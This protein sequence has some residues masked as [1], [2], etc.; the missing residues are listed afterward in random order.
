VDD[1]RDWPPFWHQGVLSCSPRAEGGSIERRPGMTLPTRNFQPSC[2]CLQ[3][4]SLVEGLDSKIDFGDLEASHFEIEI[5][6]DQGQ[7]GQLFGQHLVV[8]LSDFDK[9][10]LCNRKS[11]LLCIAQMP[12]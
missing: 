7:F 2:K 12:Y 5:Q 4:L 8:P 9:A 10:V 3:E 6:I 11:L 1:V